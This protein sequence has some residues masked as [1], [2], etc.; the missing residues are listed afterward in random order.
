M[1]VL[2]FKF[3][4]SMA[5]EVIPAE[6]AEDPEGVVKGSVLTIDNHLVVHEDGCAP[7]AAIV[8]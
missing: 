1:L 4:I 3:S 8:R 5:L 6:R 2:K 7:V